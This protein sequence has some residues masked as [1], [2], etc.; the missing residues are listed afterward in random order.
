MPVKRL[1]TFDLLITLPQWILV[2]VSVLSSL[3]LYGLDNTITA[4]VI[5]VSLGAVMRM[6]QIVDYLR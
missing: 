3:L 2:V 4:D 6:V 1:P 5:P